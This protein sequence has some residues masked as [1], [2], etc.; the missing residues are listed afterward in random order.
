MER[1]DHDAAQLLRG[2]ADIYQRAGQFPR[3]LVMLLLANQ[4]SPDDT[5]LLRSLAVVFTAVGD[6]Q[7]ALLA[8]DRIDE[9]NGDSVDE[10][11]SDLALLRSRALLRAGREEEGRSLFRLYVAERRSTVS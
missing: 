6:G 9:L 11:P 5:V 1:N 4:I 3:A 7:R 8:L 10:P 2:L